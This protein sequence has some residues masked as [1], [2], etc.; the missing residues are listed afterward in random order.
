L[1][2]I[3]RAIQASIGTFTQHV[4]TIESLSCVRANF[5]QIIGGTYCHAYVQC[6][7]QVVRLPIIIYIFANFA[8]GVITLTV[9]AAIYVKTSFDQTI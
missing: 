9:G 5:N 1:G 3:G 6:L 4:D 2:A 8:S 7:H